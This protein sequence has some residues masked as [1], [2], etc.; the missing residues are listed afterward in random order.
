M[1]EVSQEILAVNHLRQPGIQDTQLALI[2]RDSG[3]ESPHLAVEGPDGFRRTNQRG[4]GRM[5]LLK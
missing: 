5:P 2:S 3:A 1:A 4:R